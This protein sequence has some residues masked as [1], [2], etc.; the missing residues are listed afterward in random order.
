MHIIKEKFCQMMEWNTCE[1]V[2]I[3]ELLKNYSWLWYFVSWMCFSFLRQKLRVS[4]MFGR[5][6]SEST[7][8]RYIPEDLNPVMKVI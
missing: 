3:N 8:Q 2:T 7:T 6:L 4:S 5:K 1:K